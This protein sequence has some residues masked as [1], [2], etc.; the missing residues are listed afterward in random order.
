M[1]TEAHPEL[2]AYWD[3]KIF[4][5]EKLNGILAKLDDSPSLQDI[6]NSK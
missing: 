1:F 4:Q 5:E 2:A 3:E 6:K